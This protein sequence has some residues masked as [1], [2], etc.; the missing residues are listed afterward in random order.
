MER[1]KLFHEN[2]EKLKKHLQN[3]LDSEIQQK[4][5]K[6]D[7]VLLKAN[8]SHRQHNDAEKYLKNLLQKAQVENSKLFFNQKEKFKN[9]NNQ[10]HQNL[11]NFV[12]NQINDDSDNENE[13]EKQNDDNLLFK[14]K[15]Y[16]LFE[17]KIDNN[18]FLNNNKDMLNI[19]DNFNSNELNEKPENN[20]FSNNSNNFNK[21]PNERYSNVFDS[22]GIINNNNDNNYIN[23]N[24]KILE[25]SNSSNEINN[26]IN[27]LN[28]KLNINNSIKKGSLIQDNNNENNFTNINNKQL[29][30][31]PENKN[32][33]LGKIIENN[34]ENDDPEKNLKLL[35]HKIFND[36]TYTPNFKFNHNNI[37]EKYSHL[38]ENDRN[39]IYDKLIK[40][41]YI[42][43]S[44]N[45]K[46]KIKP[47]KMRSTIEDKI[48][49]AC[50]E[51]KSKKSYTAY[52]YSM[53]QKI[54]GPQKK[55]V[56]S[57]L[58]FFIF[59]YYKYRTWIF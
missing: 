6:L 3:I 4:E 50:D 54:K 44:S 7:E 47:K 39:K 41:N 12:F 5:N 40:D 21:Q 27:D 24:R 56:K 29:E 25:R 15:Y 26:F 37:N 45:D 1:L 32:K 48:K 53:I 31:I 8:I 35:N 42:P 17:N 14:K 28:F 30:N 34:L 19:C 38:N 2:E 43:Y 16:Y 11:N 36:Q 20:N 52:T 49:K 13:S 58:L 23:Q 22:F 55:N 46:T 9:N 10:L 59:K 51:N 57:K 33:N 18:F